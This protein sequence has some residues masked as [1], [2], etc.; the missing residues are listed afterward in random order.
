MN[1]AV[2]WRQ[3]GGPLYA[4]RAEL[5][6][7]ALVLAGTAPGHLESVRRLRYGEIGS[8]RLGRDSGDR[9]GGRPALV[10]DLRSVTVRI[11]PLG[12][13]GMLHELMEDLADR[14]GKA[15]G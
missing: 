5:E 3:N 6:E 11:A 15:G 10:I 12:G 14:S 8:V 4:G 13:A 7:S 2:V 9:L 1:Y